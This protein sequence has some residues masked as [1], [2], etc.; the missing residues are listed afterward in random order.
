MLFITDINDNV[1]GD[2]ISTLTKKK[3][4]AGGRVARVAARVTTCHGNPDG[5]VPGGARQT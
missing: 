5:L 1:R 3:L 4:R 2:L